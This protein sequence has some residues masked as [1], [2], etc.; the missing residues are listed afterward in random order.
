VIKEFKRVAACAD[1]T[2]LS[3]RGRKGGTSFGAPYGHLNAVNPVTVAQRLRNWEIDEFN[4]LTIALSH[5]QLFQ[6]T[7][8]AGICIVAIECK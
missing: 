2:G 4:L 7:T 6:I 3:A 8:I 1:L 5:Y